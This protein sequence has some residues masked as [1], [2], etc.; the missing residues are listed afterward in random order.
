M[1]IT[2]TASPPGA[3]E[4]STHAVAALAIGLTLLMFGLMFTFIGLIFAG[5]CLV[6]GGIVCQGTMIGSIGNTMLGF[7]VP[8]LFIGIL[9]FKRGRQAERE[10]NHVRLSRQVATATSNTQGLLVPS[11]VRTE[12]QRCGGPI[13]PGEAACEW[14]GAAIQ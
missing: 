10:A 4:P 5:L 8:A 6:E 11:I 9:L 12:C 1:S 14:C 2:V 3:S 13:Q 7:G